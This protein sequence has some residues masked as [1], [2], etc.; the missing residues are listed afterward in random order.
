MVGGTRYTIKEGDKR[1]AH[2]PSLTFKEK[3]TNER[4]Q[5][6]IGFDIEKSS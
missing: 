6:I 1:K 3:R 2:K 4:E 5:L